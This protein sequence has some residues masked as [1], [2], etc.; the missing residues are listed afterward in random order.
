MVFCWSKW[1]G[2]KHAYA[3]T[4]QQM[5]DKRREKQSFSVRFSVVSQ[6]LTSR[7]NPLLI[8]QDKFHLATDDSQTQGKA[9]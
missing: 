2:Y 6:V 8:F 9:L 3:A 7:W 1:N 5:T 4:W